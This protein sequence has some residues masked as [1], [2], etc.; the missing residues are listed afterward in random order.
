MTESVCEVM[1]GPHC[2]CHSQ[3][4]DCCFCEL[5]RDNCIDD[6]DEDEGR[7]D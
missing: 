4:Q 1:K 7:D 2:Y 3:G 5:G 6:G